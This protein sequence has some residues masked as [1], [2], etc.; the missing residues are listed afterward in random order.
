MFS[1]Q[2]PDGPPDLFRRSFF[3][4]S[5]TSSSVG[6]ESSM[7]VGSKFTGIFSPGGGTRRY[8]SVFSAVIRSSVARAGGGPL[9]A[10]ALYHPFIRRHAPLAFGGSS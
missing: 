3:T 6:T 8:S 5:S 10:A 7:L 4:A 1:A 9:F 2:I